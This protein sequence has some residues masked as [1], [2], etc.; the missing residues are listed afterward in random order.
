MSQL[1]MERARLEAERI[2][3]HD[4]EELRLHL[5]RTDPASKHPNTE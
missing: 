1:R 3:I 5:A 4:I 2:H